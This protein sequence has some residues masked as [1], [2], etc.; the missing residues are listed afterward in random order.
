[1]IDLHTRT[2]H[3]PA[4]TWH[5]SQFYI[6]QVAAITQQRPATSNAGKSQQAELQLAH[7][8]TTS[9]QLRHLRRLTGGQSVTVGHCQ[10]RLVSVWLV[11]G[12]RCRCSLS[13]FVVGD[14]F[15]CS[16]SVFVVGVRC[17]CF[18][19]SSSCSSVTAQTFDSCCHDTNIRSKLSRRS[20][21]VVCLGRL[22]TKT[23]TKVTIPVVLF[24]IFVTETLFFVLFEVLLEGTCAVRFGCCGCAHTE[25][26]SLRSS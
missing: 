24:T 16:L 11:V 5:R 17:W 18:P 21:V 26:H 15:R 7:E 1:M 23:K 9:A 4:Q 6:P 25:L 13:V 12:V 3:V 10:S 2:P 19:S 20:E 22:G 14:R 8:Q